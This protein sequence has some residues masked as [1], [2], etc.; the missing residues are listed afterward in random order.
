MKIACIGGGPAG[1]FFAILRKKADPKCEITVYD[2][3]PRGSTFGWGVVL[4]DEALKN[5]RDADAEV[6]DE[7]RNTLAHWDDIDVHIKGQ[8]IH[9]SGHG[10]CGIARDRMLEIF[11]ARAEALGIKLVFD[12]EV[13]DLEKLDADLIVACDGIFSRVRTQYAESFGTQIRRENN[14]FVWLGTKKIFPA[15]TFIFKETQWGWFQAHCYRFND[16]TSTFIVECP[17]EVWKNAGIDSMSKE[18]GI[19]FCEGLFAEYLDGHP[20]LT[21]SAHLRGSHIW[22]NFEHVENTTWHHENIVLLGDA[23]AS[24]HFSIGSGSKLALESAIAL[25]RYISEEKDLKAAFNRY[26]SER[27]VEVL[28]LQNAARNSREWFETVSLRAS[29]NPEQFGYSLLTRSQRISHENLRVRDKQYLES[30]EIAFEESATG[31]KPKKPRPPMFVP[32]KLRSLELPNRIAVS[33][34]DIYSA[35]EGV[36][37]DMH[38]VHLGS[39]AMG[40]AGLVFTEMTCVSADGRITPGCAGMYEREHVQGWKRIV[41]FIHTNSPAKVAL[42]LGHAG[43]KGS[44]GIPWEEGMDEPLKVGNWQI[45][46]PSAIA[47]GE[48]NQI[49]HEMNAS[50]MKRILDAFVQATRWG[51]EAGFDLLELHCAHG[52]LLSSFLSPLTNTRTDTYGGSV[53]NR[54]RYP[55]EVFKAMRSVWPT[56]KPMSVRISAVDWVEGGNTVHDAVKIAQAFKEAGVDIIDVS[57]GQVAKAQKPV[58]GRMWQTPFAEQVRARVGIPTMAVGNIFEADHVNT[59]I[60]SG[61]ADLCLIARPHL[62]D[63]HWTIRNAAMLGY[64]DQWWPKQYSSAKKQLEVNFKRAQ[65]LPSAGEKI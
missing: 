34:M 52:Y 33:P 32:F 7:I 64:E 25:S 28:K 62:A 37:G 53:E 6:V 31:T 47:Y 2:R 35:H 17:E 5:V 1:L 20:L 41:D 9:S 11:C 8:T 18:E 21:K 63:P 61:R 26:E 54:V 49:P 13:E 59:I 57:T 50:D 46:A 44:T 16:D 40:G 24:A 45:I 10:F 3:N 4:S 29:L 15:F 14:R 22:I 65:A 38:L 27:R 48:Q 51:N 23:A 36:P 56:S 12:H 58:Y 43:P 19:T 60:G 55:L 39:R 30:Y 42:Q